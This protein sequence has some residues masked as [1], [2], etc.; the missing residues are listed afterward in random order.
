MKKNKNT[1]NELLPC[2]FCG[3]SDFKCSGE[4]HANCLSHMV[5]CIC[6]A[7]VYGRSSAEAKNLWNKR[8]IK[9]EDTT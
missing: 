5:E 2:P 3:R 8:E 9:N 7:K 1:I 6:S 4:Y